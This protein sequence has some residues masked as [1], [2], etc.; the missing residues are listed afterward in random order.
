[1]EILNVLAAAAGSFVF[2]AVWY[3]SLSKPWMKAAGIQ[4]D[5]NGKPMGNGSPMPF[6]YSALCL[7]V[8]AGFMRHIFASSGVTTPGAG[9][10]AGLGIGLFF[11]TPWTLLNNAYAMRPFKL[12]LIDGGYATIGCAISGLILNLF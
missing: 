6:V 7:V 2:G 9:L 10:V 12:T 8:V 4:M 5:A 11:I 1:M 3:M